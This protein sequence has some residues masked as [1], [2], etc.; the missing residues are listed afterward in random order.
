MELYII[1]IL[2][3]SR[4]LEHANSNNMGLQISVWILIEIE[5][6]YP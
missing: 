2:L 5:T 1:K 6:K 3:I 4:V